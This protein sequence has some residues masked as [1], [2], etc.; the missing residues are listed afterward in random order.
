MATY[1]K[2]SIHKA[3]Y[4]S[5][6][7]A[8]R[9]QAMMTD[10]IKAAWCPSGLWPLRTSRLIAGFEPPMT[11]T[12]AGPQ[13]ARTPLGSLMTEI[14]A[15]IQD[16]A[17]ALRTPANRHFTSLT[18]RLEAAYAKIALLERDLEA[19]QEIQRLTRPRKGVTVSNNGQHHFSTP[20]VLPR[21]VEIEQGRHG[22][23]ARQTASQPARVTQDDAE[24]S[25]W[26]SPFLVSI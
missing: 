18:D 19:T 25:L 23:G 26:P 21:I 20:K 1:S 7:I 24:R 3:I 13:T 11:P 8:A 15:F 5:L 10:N 14:R 17:D 12:T 16:H 6:L 9:S 4:T 2:G 22:G